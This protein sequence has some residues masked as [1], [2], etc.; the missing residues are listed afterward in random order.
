MQRLVGPALTALA[1][2]LAIATV[3]VVFGEFRFASD[4][5]LAL[6]GL[7]FLTGSG[8]SLVELGQRIHQLVRF[9]LTDIHDE[10]DIHTSGPGRRWLR[11]ETTVAA[12]DDPVRGVLDDS[13]AVAVTVE[14]SVRERLAQFPWLSTQVGTHSERTSAVPVGL[15]H[16]S[17]DTVFT[18]TGT[19][20]TLGHDLRVVGGDC[21]ELTV[22]D[23][24]P[25]HTRTALADLGITVETALFRGRVFEHYVRIAEATVPNRATVQ[26]FGPVVVENTASGRTLRPAGRFASRPLMTTDGWRAIL[27]RIGRRLAI[28]S[29]VAP[30]TGFCGW[31]LLSVAGRSLLG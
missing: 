20:R 24:V 4:L 29:L 1:V 17:T 8:L 15:G 31:L 3:G 7:A 10:S 2:L 30:L 21:R 22:D 26:L 16:S 18:A 5:A 23:D 25:P 28:L 13:P 14:C 9:G 11:I 12:E 6:L 27:K 19:A